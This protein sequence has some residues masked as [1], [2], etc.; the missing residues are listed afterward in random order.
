MESVVINEAAPES[1][2]SETVQ[3]S[4]ARVR[5]PFEPDPGRAVPYRLEAPA[6][7]LVGEYGARRF[8]RGAEPPEVFARGLTSPEVWA[9]PRPPWVGGPDGSDVDELV[10]QMDVNGLSRSQRA[11]I[12][13]YLGV[14]V[15]RA[16]VTDRKTA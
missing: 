16:Q 11:A 9:E 6:T 13:G 12:F 10:A 7:V 15:E 8:P 1:V 2:W 4:N 5:G 14:P 3:P